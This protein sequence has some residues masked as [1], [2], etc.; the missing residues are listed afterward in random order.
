MSEIKPDESNSPTHV[1][2][3]VGDPDPT[4]ESNDDVDLC[5]YECYPV[6]LCTW[7]QGHDGQHVAG[8]IG[9]IVGVAD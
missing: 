3:S 5:E 2:Y 7:G 8:G 6:G 1:R 4:P 9:T